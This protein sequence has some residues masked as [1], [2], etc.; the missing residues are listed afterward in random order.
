M[1][2]GINGKVAVVTAASKG[3]GFAVAKKLAEEGANL[4]I[5]SRRKENL[6]N[7]KAELSYTGVKIVSVS[8]DLK[9]KETI[10]NIYNAAMENFGKVDIL[11]LNAGGPRPGGFFDVDEKDWRETFEMNFMSAQRLVRLIAPNMIKNRWGRIIFLTSIS[12]RNPIKNLILSNS[13][14]MAITGMMKTLSLELAEHNITVNA[15][16]PG[17]TLTDRVKQLLE[18]KAKR[19]GKTYEEVMKELSSVIPVHR[20]GKPEEIASVVAFLASK[21]AAFLTGQTIVVDGGQD[22][23]SV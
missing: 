1:D 9:E 21:S 4:V 6:N 12:V 7:A 2:L 10:E 17:Y 20:L 18:D 19:T 16:A 3:I 22:A 23:T 8:G 11:F 15:V 14:R 5:N 13:I